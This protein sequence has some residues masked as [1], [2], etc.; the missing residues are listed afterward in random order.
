MANV[1]NI[2][3]LEYLKS[4]NTPDYKDGNWLINP[5]LPDCA[6]KYWKIAGENVE[7]M[8]AS[9]KAAVDAAEQAI[10]EA[11]ANKAERDRL[12]QER[13]WKIAEDQLIAEGVIEEE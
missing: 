1:L 8:S 13:M 4:V 11:A 6:P 3:T 5:Q 10:A 12:I 9:E 7:E 2:H